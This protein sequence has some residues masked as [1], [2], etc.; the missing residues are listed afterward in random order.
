MP[1]SNSAVVLLV[2]VKIGWLCNRCASLF[3]R[4]KILSEDPYLKSFISRVCLKHRGRFCSF[5]L[6]ATQPRTGAA[7][8]LPPLHRGFSTKAVNQSS[9]NTSRWYWMVFEKVVLFGE[10]A[11]VDVIQF[12]SGTKHSKKI[13]V[14]WYW[15]LRNELRCFSEYL[16]ESTAPCID[17][18][19][20]FF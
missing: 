7:F 14:A 19:V 5:S 8:F 20:L 18:L 11:I 1:E 17:Q 6:Y 15:K 3:S 16:Q 13:R 12:Q 9:I 10:K 2:S 4:T